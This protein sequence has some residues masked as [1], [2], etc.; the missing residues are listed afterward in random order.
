MGSARGLS[1]SQKKHPSHIQTNPDQDDAYW[2]YEYDGRL[3]LTKA[4]RDNSSDELQKRYTYTYDDGDNMLTKVVYDA[5]GESTT[6]TA[7]EYTNANEL[8]K[9]TVGGTV[10]NFTYDKYGR[11][12]AKTQG[13]Y[14]AAYAYRYSQMLYSVT[15]DFPGEGTVTY[16]YGGDLKRRSRT[17]SGTTT[18][19]NWD[20]GY[21]VI[22]EEDS[23]GDL[24]MTYI[25]KLADVSGDDPSS[26]TWRYYSHDHLGSTRR[27]RDASKSSL[28]QYEYTPYG[29]IY[30][31][32]GATIT[33]EFTSH[34]WDDTSDLYFAP[35]RYY[36]PS[37]AR[38]TTPDPV[39][40]ID[41]PNQYAYVANSPVMGMDFLGTFSLIEFV[42]VVAIV[43]VVAVIVASSLIQLRPDRQVRERTIHRAWWQIATLRR[44]DPNK[45]GHYI[46][47][48]SAV[49]W[50]DATRHYE[51][52]GD[53]RRTDPTIISG[54]GQAYYDKGLRMFNYD[55]NGR[56]HRYVLPMPKN[57]GEWKNP[58]D[59][60][61]EEHRDRFRS[62]WEMYQEGYS[63]PPIER[64]CDKPPF[65]R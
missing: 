39:G 35:Y 8:T 16:Q 11:M 33:N 62:I 40:M 15:S 20:A 26:G 21:S 55:A 25:G 44:P 29:E 48:G 50:E 56:T 49:C 42:V 59:L 22:N 6:T 12:T 13:G 14:S 58:L 5:V 9:Q 41:G 63:M 1:F 23:G 2:E 36:N 53:V 47:S 4:E 61:P 17:V 19:Y 28:G 52:A 46:Y 34:A 51:T 27:L 38:W 45:P 31:E 60:V 32:T 30:A 18:N 37:F 24:T 10:T 7:F 57:E 65:Y 64:P 3:R 54:T 43:V